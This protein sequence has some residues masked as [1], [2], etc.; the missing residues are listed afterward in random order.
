MFLYQKMAQKKITET[1]LGHKKKLPKKFLG[2]FLGVF[3]YTNSK[4][5][6]LFTISSA[7]KHQSYLKFGM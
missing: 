3:L 5:M 7:I 2:H 1:F 6:C 4:M